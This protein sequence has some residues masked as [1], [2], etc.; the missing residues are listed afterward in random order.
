MSKGPK[1]KLFLKLVKPLQDELNQE[2]D[3]DKLLTEQLEAITESL[4]SMTNELE[5]RSKLSFAIHE[6]L[7]DL[8]VK[9]KRQP[10]PPPWRPL[11]HGTNVWPRLNETFPTDD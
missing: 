11:L 8:E 7:W 9:T 6:Q 2:R 10:T 3:Q 1:D 5:N 4:S